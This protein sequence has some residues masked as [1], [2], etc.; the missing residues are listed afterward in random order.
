MGLIATNTIAQGDTRQTALDAISN[1]GGIIYNATN[2]QPWPGMAAVIV[3]VVHIAKHLNNLL[4]LLDGRQVKNIS[5]ALDTSKVTGD[6]HILNQNEGRSH[7]GTNVVGVGFIIPPEEAEKLIAKNQSNKDI[8]FPF[9]N[10]QD[11]N[12]SPTQSPSRWIINFF[13]WPL[14]K[15]E[16]YPGCMAIVRER[17][18]PERIKKKGSYAKL[19]WQY[20]RRQDKLYEAIAPLNRVLIVA[21]TS[22]TLAFVFV[23]KGMVYSHATILFAF[24]ENRYFSLLQSSFHTSWVLCYGSTLKGDA[25]YIPTDC[26]Q[27]FPFPDSDPAAPNSELDAIG[28]TYHEHRR[29]LCSPAR[30]G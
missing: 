16:A 30:K 1:H 10:G 20:G 7:M 4:L 27:T 17:V 15:A 8:L 12:T 21:Q 9:I 25:R 14:D 19:W 18:Y 22:K 13:N 2:S 3:S 6:P 23:P 11:L 5:S 26:F 29:K 24:D 28:K